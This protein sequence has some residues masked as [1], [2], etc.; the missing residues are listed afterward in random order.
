MKGINKRKRG[1]MVWDE[2]GKEWKPRWGYKR[3]NDN[4]KDWCIKVPQQADSFEDQFAKRQKE[5]KAA[6]AK[7]E[8]QRLRTLHAT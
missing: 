6:V 5:K 4:T 8:L 7:N 3:A 1:R 2:T